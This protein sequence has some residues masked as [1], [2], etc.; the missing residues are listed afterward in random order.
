MEVKKSQQLSQTCF[1][2]GVIIIC[3]YRV[4][5]SCVQHSQ[6][7]NTWPCPRK[8]SVCM[9]HAKTSLLKAD[10]Q[11][12]PKIVSKRFNPLLDIATMCTSTPPG[13]FY[14]DFS[15]LHSLACKFRP[16]IIIAHHQHHLESH[17]L[18]VVH[19]ILLAVHIDFYQFCGLIS[20]PNHS[21]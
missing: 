18:E 1:S 3:K 6:S 19:D 2:L 8:L 14:I 10:L 12:F 15:L 4:R 16:L 5:A 20:S 13:P 17:P 11:M 9:F 21:E 7:P